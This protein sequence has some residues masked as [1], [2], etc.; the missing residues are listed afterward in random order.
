MSSLHKE[1]TINAPADEVW[2]AVRD[3]GRPHERITPGVLTGAAQ[4]PDRQRR[5]AVGH[6]ASVSPHPDVSRGE[7]RPP[8]PS[9]RR[10]PSGQRR[11]SSPEEMASHDPFVAL[12]V[13]LP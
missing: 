12:W 4:E 3:V 1:V 5:L 6:G 8:T 13:R 2:D 10:R 7:H 9:N 11:W